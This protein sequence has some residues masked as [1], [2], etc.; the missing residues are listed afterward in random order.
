MQT[1]KII[2]QKVEA[3]GITEDKMNILSDENTIKDSE[4]NN[5]DEGV[6]LDEIILKSESFLNNELTEGDFTKWAFDHIKVRPYIPI[7]EKTLIISNF[8]YI[9]S[10][11]EDVDDPSWVISEMEQKK[12]WYIM[13][14]YT[15]IKTSEYSSW[16]N[17]SSYD[18]LQQ[19]IG[20]W[21]QLICGADYNRIVKMID[22]SMNYIRIHEMLSVFD[23]F[24]T[25]NL[26][27]YA[28][29]AKAQLEYFESHKD[30]LEYISNIFKNTTRFVNNKE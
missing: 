2:E 16:M 11:D 18:I 10:I 22:D 3:A 7:I 1:E 23:R 9:D 15:N 20:S 21:L 27:K 4:N 17:S 19:S 13:L 26:S 28:D 14:K 29:D 30:S 12:F 25:D 6:G 24:D 8:L 5:V